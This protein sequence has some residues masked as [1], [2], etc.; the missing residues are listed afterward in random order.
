MIRVLHVIRVMDRAGAETFIMNL[1]RS[2]DRTKVQFD[3]LVNVQHEGDYD[4]E[5]RSLGGRIFSIPRYNI[6]NALA[7][8]R[9]CRDFFMSHPEIQ[10]VHG[11]IGSSAPIYLTE[12]RRAGKYAIAHSHTA[13][14]LDSPSHILFKAMCLPVRGRADYY[15]ACSEEAARD[16]FGRAISS[17][18]ASIIVH[19]GIELS[20]Y[21]RNE[22]RIR[23]CKQR[24]DICDSAAFGHIGRFASEKNHTFLLSAFARIREQLPNAKLLLAG[25][26]PDRTKVE[27]QANALGLDDDII[28][29]GIC[30]DIPDVLC[31]ID[32]FLF[33]SVYEGLGIAFIEAQAAGLECIGSTGIPKMAQITERARRIPIESPEQWALEGIEAYQRSQLHTDDQRNTVRASGFDIKETAE[34]MQSFYENAIGGHRLSPQASLPAI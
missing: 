27:K 21:N 1:Y 28:F 33:P 3:F 17:G 7:Y 22:R 32:V 15:M 26:G 12:A 29:L 6:V 20:R 13:T 9:A 25:D 30:E 23:L 11:H 5:I 19:N 2:I 18:A 14:P 16:R 8:K 4:E 31:A 24:L 34:R 10:I